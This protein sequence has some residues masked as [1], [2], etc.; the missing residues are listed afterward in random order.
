MSLNYALLAEKPDVA[1]R[2]IDAGADL[3]KSSPIGKVPP[4]LL[5]VYSENGNV[6]L[7][8]AMI[9]RGANVTATN[10]AGETALTW[11]RRRGFPDAIALLAGVGT[12]DPADVR[13]ELPNR[14]LPKMRNRVGSSCAGPSRKASSYCSTAPTHF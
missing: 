1:M 8:R 11:A 3:K 6:S 4:I 13:P 10:K 12:P 2:L 14:Q 5:A 9:E 7:A